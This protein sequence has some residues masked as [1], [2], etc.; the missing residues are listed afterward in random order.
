MDQDYLRGG[1]KS[2]FIYLTEAGIKEA[3]QLM[4]K[5]FVREM[6]KVNNLKDF[7]QRCFEHW[8]K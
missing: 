5:Y 2:K 3:K 6:K 8:R 4:E 7:I 1:L